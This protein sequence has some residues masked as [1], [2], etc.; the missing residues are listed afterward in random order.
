MLVAEPDRF[1]RLRETVTFRDDGLPCWLRSSV[2]VL[3][4]GA[5]GN[6]LAVGVVRSGATVG[7]VDFDTGT[8]ENQGTQN[9]MPGRSKVSGVV[10]ACEAISADR[11]LGFECDARHV[12]IGTLRQFDLL[13]DCTD[14]PNLAW[15]LTETSNGLGM[16]LLRCALDGSGATESGRILCSH[17]GAG[18]ACQ[19]CSYD[20][21]DLHPG[22][23]RMSCPHDST[24][25]HVPTVAG[26]AMAM[27]VAGIGLLSA[28][29][30]LTGNDAEQVWGH[31][32][33]LDLTHGQLLPMKLVRSDRCLSGHVRWEL[34]PFDAFAADT[35]VA[36]VFDRASVELAAV[37]ITIEPY[38]HPLCV[39]AEC[40][41]GQVVQA[42]G[43]QW[44]APP[45][46]SRCGRAMTWR[47]AAQYD[48][49]SRQLASNLGILD[50]SLAK[51]GLPELGAMLVAR[52]PERPPV[53][54]VLK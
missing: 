8:I 42:V 34:V 31:E 32:T 6:P 46:C 50:T 40:S 41:C 13:I 45:E 11:A 29:R 23:Q 5:V 12:G 52:G 4:L 39:Q 38:L 44:A 51:L 43:S 20:L 14:D 21:K 17:G 15:P 24:P 22:R 49:I 54:Y 19:I 2:A 7:V 25:T 9:V 16:P 48:R 18:H 36:E 3:G 27:A 53:R 30:L 47:R 37:D 33:L 10:A 1:V 26:G 28:Q 35:S